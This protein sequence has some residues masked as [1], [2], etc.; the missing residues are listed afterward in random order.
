MQWTN[1]FQNVYTKA[2]F[3]NT[4]FLSTLG[5]H[6]Y[7][8]LSPTAAAS[9]IAY[10]A[11]DPRWVL[12]DHTYAKTFTSASGNVAI[13]VVQVDSTPLHDRYLFSGASGGAYATDASGADT[14]VDN[15]AGNAVLNAG[16]T[17]ANGWT[18]ANGWT[19]G[20][21]FNASNFACG[22]CTTGATAAQCGYNL[23]TG[24]SLKPYGNAKVPSGCKYAS[25]EL[26]QFAHPAARAA[27]WTNISATLQAAYGT[28]QY[29]V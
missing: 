9:Q 11:V 24:A 21:L 29:Q 27:T 5:N 6:D 13:Q 7:S 26:A 3:N 25:P 16:V 28:V 12:P 15:V 2:L 22:N 1:A 14:L 17:A 19:S 23:T 4:P 18:P 10:S 20:N 8:I